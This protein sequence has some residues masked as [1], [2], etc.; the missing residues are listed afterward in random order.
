MVA[1]FENVALWHERDI[2]HSSVER[3]IMPDSTIALDHMLTK[4]AALV[5][6]LRV[7]PKRMMANINLTHG[8]VHS[9]QL[10]LFLT[11][12]GIPRDK[13]Y[14][15]VQRNAMRA[16]ETGEH[17]RVL[18]EADGEVMARVSS[19]ELDKVFDLDV[20]FKDVDRTFRAV[21]L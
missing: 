3:V 1:A 16:W 19:S 12:Q 13:A 8:L 18:V 21:G 7:F 5:R 20:H 2:S 10:L 14:R 11:D 6:N 4:L 15:M 9:Q 17:L